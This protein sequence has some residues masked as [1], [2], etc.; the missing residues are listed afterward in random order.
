MSSAA[1]MPMMDGGARRRHPR[2]QISFPFDITVFRPSAVTRLSGQAQDLGEGGLSG[3]IS[4]AALP[5]ERVE[6][7]LLLPGSPVPVN[8]R[9]V[10]RHESNLYCGFEFLSLDQAQRELLQQLATDPTLQAGL[11]NETEWEAGLEPPLHGEAPLCSACGEELPEEIPVCLACGTV[12]PVEDTFE[13]DTAPPAE[14]A[15]AAHQ[16]ASARENPRRGFELDSLIAIIFLIT[17]MVGLWE[18]LNA[19]ADTGADS[20]PGAVTVA[21]ENAF[22]RPSPTAKQTSPALGFNSNAVLAEAGSVVSAIIGSA[23][24]VEAAGEDPENAARDSRG[25]G[26]PRS[27][28]NSQAYL[29]TPESSARSEVASGQSG[30]PSSPLLSAPAPANA[31]VAAESNG[32]SESTAGKAASNFAGMLLQKV[33]PVYPAQAQREGVQG[34]VVLKAVIGKDGAVAE[35]TPLQGPQQLTAAAMDAVR[36]W[37]FRPY[38]ANGKP[39]TVETNIRLNFQLPKNQ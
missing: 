17:L 29:N 5:G 32:N 10:V 30:P 12:R 22:L 11:I 16:P 7:T 31:D 1:A 8:T 21:L 26:R 19:P 24:P 4:G 2:F 25:Q 33:L 27:N 34:Q 28:S 37:R 14:A 3:V 6:L 9:A 23:S 18:W 39:V 15:S 36:H 20:H 35:L 38:Q 13:A